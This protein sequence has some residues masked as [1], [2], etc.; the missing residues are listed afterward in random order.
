MK[1]NIK[2]TKG[3]GKQIISNVRKAKT[4]PSNQNSPFCICSHPGPILHSQGGE[5]LKE[6]RKQRFTIF[7]ISS[8][9][10][11]KIKP[12]SKNIF[13]QL[14]GVAASNPLLQNKVQLFTT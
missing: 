6:L 2:G 10:N 11:R 4:F 13:H 12:Y 14:N 7:Y 5:A 8:T 1:V 3:K 9:L